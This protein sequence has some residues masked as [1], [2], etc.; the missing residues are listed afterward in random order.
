MAAGSPA[1]RTGDRVAPHGV[2]TKSA[3]RGRR[4]FARAAILDV[5]RWVSI[6]V[7]LLTGCAARQPPPLPV[8]EADPGRIRAVARLTPRA[9]DVQPIAV[10]LTNGGPEPLQVDPRQMFALAD[11]E[12]RIA[13]LPPAEAARRAGGRRLPGAVGH[14]AVG[15]ATGGAFGAL[16][17]IVAG[18]IQGGIGAA[19]A[20][21]SAVGATVGAVAGAVG[22]GG[23]PAPDVAGFED[24]A[25]HATSLAPGLSAEG[26]LYFPT[27]R[28]ATL[29]LLFATAGEPAPRR[30]RVPIE[31][32][33]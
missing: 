27:G 13:P 5:T 21:G 8:P 31:P 29:E 33:P 4:V 19:V 24:Q 1:S 18:A 26:H 3:D 20:V 10:A 25:L 32:A 22:G 15:A 14:A 6:A 23:A 11:G 9:G 16:G 30:E 28:Y 12:A 7:A 2:R 17:G